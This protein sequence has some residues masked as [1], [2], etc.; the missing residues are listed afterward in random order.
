[1]NGADFLIVGSPRSGTTLV[2]RLVGDLAGVQTPPET[3]FFDVFLLPLLAACSFPLDAS[4]IYAALHSWSRLD[5]SQGID[6]NADAIV[7]GLG[8]TC[9]SPGALFDALVTHL[10]P[11]ATVRG[12]KTPLHLRWWRP[13]ARRNPQLV[14]V[15]VVREPRAVVASSLTV[16]WGPGLVYGDWGAAL[17]LGIAYRWRQTQRDTRD[18]LTALPDRSLLLRYEDVVRDPEAARRSLA[19]LLGRPRQAIRSP[20]VPAMVLPWETW[21]ASALGPITEEPV[22]RW[23]ET[24]S[25]AVAATIAAMCGAPMRQLGYPVAR[26]EI[27]RGTAAMATLPPRTWRQL[28]GF[29]KILIA[30]RRTIEEQVL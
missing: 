10:T 11:D 17:P 14:F 20:T 26:G 16:P 8:G 18:L 1:M 12:E 22:S 7:A 15:V 28:R 13:L 30:E 21:K 27:M 3:H 2:Q 4:G 5:V 19:Q 6:V 29:R 23:R 24:L 25:P 9:A